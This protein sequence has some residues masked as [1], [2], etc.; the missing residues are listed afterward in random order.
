MKKNETKKP[1]SLG[2]QKKLL[3][4]NP[5]EQKKPQAVYGTPWG[6]PSIAPYVNQD[7]SQNYDFQNKGR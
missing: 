7:G 4:G 6:R 5:S 3:S 1:V 2:E